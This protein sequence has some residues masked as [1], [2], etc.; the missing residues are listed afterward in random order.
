MS[1]TRNYSEDELV[2]EERLALAAL[3]EGVRVAGLGAA[4]ALPAGIA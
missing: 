3:R 4:G 2:V 1:E